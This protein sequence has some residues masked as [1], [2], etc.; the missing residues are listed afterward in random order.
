MKDIPTTESNSHMSS[1]EG[2]L[3]TD[4]FGNVTMTFIWCANNAFVERVMEER[5][6]GDCLVK[7]VALDD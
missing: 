6:K 4:Y 5:K 1:V 7:Y 3:D 2:Y